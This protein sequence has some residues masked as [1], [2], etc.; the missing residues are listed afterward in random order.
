MLHDALYLASRDIWRMLRGRETIVW[1]FIMPVVFFYFLGTITSGFKGP[2]DS[3]DVLA[4]RAAPDAG[5][6]ADQLI[7]RLGRQDY[8]VERAATQEEF[9]R[10]NRR[11]AIPAGFTA[12][13]LAGKPAKVTFTRTGENL[14]ADYDRIRISRSV[15]TLLADLIVLNRRHDRVTP[16]GLTEVA[17]TP[18]TLILDVKSAGARRSPPTGFEQAV[19]GTMV[20]FVLLVM[21]TSGAVTLTI[22]RNYGLLRRL[23]SAPMSR[24][25]IVL[26]KW[27]ARMG[28]GVIQIAFAMITGRVL[29]HFHWGPNL[30][31]ITL[32]LLAYG[33][34]AAA[35]GMLLGNLGRSEGQVIAL[36]VISTNVFAALGGCWWP[37]EVTPLWA[38]RL[39][40][41]FPTGWVMD[42]LHRL[43]SFGA[44][45]VTVL[46]H[47]F[48]LSGAALAAGYAISRSFRFQ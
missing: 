45:P 4:V 16:E 38:Q 5:F 27:G 36:G 47:F 46:P 42:A 9:N 48:I 41:L 40:L 6:L 20:M 10:Y 39:S 18:R 24:G 31:M 14:D 25:A 37:I 17:A 12:S 33:A 23:A 7:A 29:F 19:P 32:V 13:V 30:P 22:E 28:L 11:L 34:L 21:F 26:G 3:R 35:L 2:A 15:Y 8:R 43:I 44:A 1:T